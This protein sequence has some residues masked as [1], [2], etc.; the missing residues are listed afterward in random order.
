MAVSMDWSLSHRPPILVIVFILF[1]EFVLM[2]FC[3]SYKRKLSSVVVF[4]FPLILSDPGLQ[5]L[6]HAVSYIAG[7]SQGSFSNLHH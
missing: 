2:K 4:F 1:S 3:Y 5:N 7:L 6:S